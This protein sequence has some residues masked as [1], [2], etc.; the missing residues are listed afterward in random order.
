MISLF[1]IPIGGVKLFDAEAIIKGFVFS[2]LLILALHYGI[3]LFV[4]A[5]RNFKEGRWARGIFWIIFIAL[6]AGAFIYVARLNSVYLILSYIFLSIYLLLILS[7]GFF[8]WYVRTDEISR[9][10]DRILK[11]LESGQK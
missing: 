3:V 2:L 8:A 4:N 6:V 9:K 7:R 5:F 11:I 10:L 1:G